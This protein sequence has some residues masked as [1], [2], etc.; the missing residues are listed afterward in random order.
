MCTGQAS[1]MPELNVSTD[2]PQLE[3]YLQ[4]EGGQFIFGVLRLLAFLCLVA[5]Q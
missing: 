2:T 3:V 5:W 4:D 1:P